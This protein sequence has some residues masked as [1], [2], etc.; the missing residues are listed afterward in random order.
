MHATATSRTSPPGRRLVTPSTL[1]KPWPRPRPRNGPPKWA[2]AW[3]T[4]PGRVCAWIATAKGRSAPRT[5]DITGVSCESCHGASGGETGWLNLHGSYGA[6]GVTREMETPEHKKTRHEAEDAA[7]MVRPAQM[8]ALAKNCFGCHTVPN[9]S[10]QTK[11]DHPKG[12]ASFELVSLVSGD[13]A[14][15]LFL[16]PKKNAEAPTL[17]MAETRPHGGGAQTIAVRL[18]PNGGPRCLAAQ[19]G[20]RQRGQRLYHCDEGTRDRRPPAIWTP[21]RTSCP[22]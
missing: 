20:G 3:P 11:T 5:L 10:L 12:T 4:S 9:E 14:H 8:Y 15:N 16:D 22:K 6:K 13:V 18:R 1:K 17:W 21:S 7:G 2:S 19:P